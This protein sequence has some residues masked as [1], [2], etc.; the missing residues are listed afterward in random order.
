MPWLGLDDEEGLWFNGEI[1]KG[2]MS[3]KTAKAV[4]D[5]ESFDGVRR[6]ED[7]L[8]GKNSSYL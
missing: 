5:V 6:R 7:A 8:G 2:G 1:R 4:E 3:S